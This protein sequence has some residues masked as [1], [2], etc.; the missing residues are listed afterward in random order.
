MCCDLSDA[1]A[2]VVQENVSKSQILEHLRC[3]DSAD[4]FFARRPSADLS[5]N[6]TRSSSPVQKGNT[7]TQ[8]LVGLRSP[9]RLYKVGCST[10]SI[11]CIFLSHHAAHLIRLRRALR[12]L[13]R[14]LYPLDS[15]SPL[16]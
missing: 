13:K 6:G 12:H 4:S 1:V 10:H 8:A 11:T 2:D 7:M 9:S 16:Q 14:W 15:H 3:T 5:H